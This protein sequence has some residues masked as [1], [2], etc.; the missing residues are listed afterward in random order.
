MFNFGHPAPIE[1]VARKVEHQLA[2]RFISNGDKAVGV[3][4]YLFIIM[5]CGL[6]AEAQ[7]PDT[8]RH[9][10]RAP[11][12]GF[13]GGAQLGS[14]VAVSDRLIVAG[15]PYDDLGGEDA[16]VVKVFDTETGL[17][18][19]VL[20]NPTPS[21]TPVAG[22][23][24]DQFGASVAISGTWV[25]VGASRDSSAVRDAGSVYLYDLSTATPT[26]P[27]ARLNN[28]NP[29]VGDFFG[30][31]VAM[32][33]TRLVIGSR[34]GGVYVYDLAS[35]TPTLPVTT[36][37]NPN[38]TPLQAFGWGVAISG[39]RVV[40]GSQYDN[41]GPLGFGSVYVYDLA[42]ATPN[43]PVVTIHNPSASQAANFGS[44][45]AISGTWAVVGGYHDESGDKAY[46]YDLAGETPTEPAITFTNPYPT[47]SDLYGWS[48]A[49]DQTRVA[50]G[51]PGEGTTG[52]VFVYDVASATPTDAGG[53]A[54]EPEPG[55]GGAI[56]LGAG[57]L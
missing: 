21:G 53:C 3:S 20:I 23:V 28:A 18:L 15:A 25:V 31:S 22:V 36:L 52:T 34:A 19:H 17:L 44:A 12:F 48:V 5:A 29:Q 45:V 9:E 8:L 2:K 51:N 41:T 1:K 49:I 56:R 37:D 54:A 13:Q 47:A 39:T 7:Q 11:P 27:V 38:P 32:S 50:V 24:A 16:G 57:N 42:S 40:V 43:L 14:S 33:G 30:S 35:S 55:D 10:I 6:R 46:V 4:R 26:V